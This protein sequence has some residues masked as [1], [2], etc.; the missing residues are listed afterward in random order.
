[1]DVADAKN[2]V[3]LARVLDRVVPHGNDRKAVS[4]LIGADARRSWNVAVLGYVTLVLQIPKGCVVQLAHGIEVLVVVAFELPEF[5]QVVHRATVED[6]RAGSRGRIGGVWIPDHLACNRVPLHVGIGHRAFPGLIHRR[7]HKLLPRA[8][9][10]AVTQA[11][12]IVEKSEDPD[13]QLI[14]VLVNQPFGFVAVSILAAIRLEQARDTYLDP[15]AEPVTP[16]GTRTACRVV[17]TDVVVDVV[18]LEPEVHFAAASVDAH[19][20]PAS[21]ERSCAQHLRGVIATRGQSTVRKVVALPGVT[22]LL[23][24]GFARRVNDTVTAS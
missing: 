11:M 16:V 7:P 15:Y 8:Q 2:D 4:R 6:R 13:A 18:T 24:P 14:R 5:I 21:I 22:S 3:R 17:R 20:H 10:A 1:V 23:E 19:A 9:D 12:V